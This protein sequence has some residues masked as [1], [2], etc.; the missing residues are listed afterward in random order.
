[1]SNN[2]IISGN[3]QQ[4][5]SDVYT[6]EVLGAISSLAHFNKDIKE[7]MSVRMQLRAERQQ[8][9]KRIEFLNEDSYIPRTKIKVKDARQGKFAGAVIPGDLNRQWR[10]GTG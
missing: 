4:A 8:Q 6:P 5:Y 10:Q 3:I 9:Q 1:M 7:A 2:F